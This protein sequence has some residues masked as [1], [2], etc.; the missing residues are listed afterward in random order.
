MD[1][2]HRSTWLTATALVV[3]GLGTAGGT[4]SS[5]LAQP[6]AAGRAPA[7]SSVPLVRPAV[8]IAIADDNLVLAGDGCT[9]IVVSPASLAQRVVHRS[10]PP[11]GDVS[12]ES[13]AG[14]PDV[15]LRITWGP[16]A[17]A[18][19]TEHI[20]PDSEHAT[21][22]PVLITMSNWDWIHSG[23]AAVGSGSIWIYGLGATSGPQLLELSASTGALEHRFVVNAGVDP[24]MVVGVSGAWITQ[25]VFG[26]DECNPTCALYHL[27]RGS[28]RA[29]V[30]R[31]TR[32]IGDEWLAVDGKRVVLDIVSETSVGYVQRIEGVA[33]ATGRMSFET[34]ARLLPA[35][36]FA[37]F[38]SLVV[39]SSL[40]L[41]TLSELEPHAGTPTTVSC[42]HGAPVEVIRIDPTTGAQSELAVLPARAVRRDC[43]SVPLI[44]GQAVVYEGALYFLSDPTS[45]GQLPL[46]R[47]VRVRL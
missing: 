35:P 29:V 36:S 39:S 26:G 14:A 47:L 19:Q 45:V 27:A 23:G 5:V 10:C 31:R 40:G 37:G 20:D 41:V 15:R 43:S 17:D 22:G 1:N 33:A 13:L 21:V 32:G 11:G 18:I 16:V 46:S 38:G 42:A 25:G 30:V 44:A 34:P 8:S 12:V 9:T 2:V 28:S 7:V 3:V 6:A 24:L 4:A